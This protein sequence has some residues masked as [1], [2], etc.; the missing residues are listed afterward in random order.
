MTL[1]SYKKGSVLYINLWKQLTYPLTHETTTK[2]VLHLIQGWSVFVIQYVLNVTENEHIRSE[3][4]CFILQLS[5][6]VKF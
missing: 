5:Q 3:Q 6:S 1:Q 4:S 2:Q